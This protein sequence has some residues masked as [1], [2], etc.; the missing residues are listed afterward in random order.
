M[1]KK[2]HAKEA[3]LRSVRLRS[4][5]IEIDLWLNARFPRQRVPLRYVPP[6]Q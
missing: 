6:F 4:P 2:G 1:A 3:T 5:R